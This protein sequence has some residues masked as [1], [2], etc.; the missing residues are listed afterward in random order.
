M[1]DEVTTGPPSAT[2]FG[3]RESAD[4]TRQAQQGIVNDA[5]VDTNFN[6]VLARMQGQT[7]TQ[8]GV[9]AEANADL[10]NKLFGHQAAKMIDK[11]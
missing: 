8:M 3:P 9:N 4:E 5:P 2:G 1:P 6:A 10:R 11:T 7:I